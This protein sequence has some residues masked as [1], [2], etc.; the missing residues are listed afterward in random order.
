MEFSLDDNKNRVTHD[1]VINTISSRTNIA[2]YEKTNNNSN[3]LLNALKDNIVGQDE[4]I[5]NLIDVTKRI[6][7]GSERK[8][9]SF[10]FVGP[11]GVGKSSLVKEYAKLTAGEENFIRLDMSEYSDS[12]SINKLIGSAPGY[13]GYDDNKNVFEIVRDKPHSIILLDEIDKAH[14]TIL[15]LLYQILDEGK[16]K[17]SKG[18]TIRFDNVIIFMTSNIGCEKGKIGFNKN[19]GMVINNS[20]KEYFNN[21]FINRI[22]NIFVFNRLNKDN[23]EEIIK[24]KLNNIKNKYPNIE[25]EYSEELVNNILN[26]SEYCDCGARKIDKIIYNSVE[27]KVID[28]IISK[29]GETIL[30]M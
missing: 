24:K 14:P 29:K 4:I 27:D 18:K 1:D 19:N 5:D 11:S 9:N 20:L 6:R 17:D 10:L 30:K 12:T 26:M 21:S 16:I 22:D 7:H 28:M 2:I 3:C 13:I 15:N 8:C 23:M 25:F